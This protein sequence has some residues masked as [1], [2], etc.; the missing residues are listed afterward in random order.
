MAF[1]KGA[2]SWSDPV[3]IPSTSS[4]IDTN[5]AGILPN[6]TFMGFYRHDNNSMCHIIR[7]Y[8][9]NYASTYV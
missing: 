9:W 3:L 2:E 1:V 6:G 8:D 5:M 7:A 4:L